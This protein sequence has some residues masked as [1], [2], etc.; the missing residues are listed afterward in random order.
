MNIRVDSAQGIRSFV[1]RE[2][3]MTRAQQR[4]FAELW[5]RF[6]INSG[7]AQLDLEQT[8]GR[9]QS[10]VLEI[11]FGD[12]ESLAAM[13]AAD[14]ETDYLGI[15]VHRPG[16]GHLLLQ[17][18]QL[19]LGNLRIL[20]ADAM[21]SVER[22]LPDECLDRIQI[23][24]PDPWPKVRH[25]K[26]RL[27]RPSFIAL[28]ARKAKPKGQLL[29]ATDCEDYARSILESLNAAPEWLNTATGDGFALPPPQRLP[30]KFEQRG[31]R[32][33]HVVREM[34][35]VRR[36]ASAKPSSA[37]ERHGDKNYG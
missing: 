5:G 33:G 17:A 13:A 34:A 1:R 10:L 37:A 16:I 28:L 25:H 18:A 36:A 20:C 7:V 8:F 4:A 2:S 35:F 12:G 24:F 11:G 23:F 3:R 14:P 15:E 29:I 27:I 9:R 31:Q 30:T 22:L 19:G 6:G 21:E 26:R 32:L